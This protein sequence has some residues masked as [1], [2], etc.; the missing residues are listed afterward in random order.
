[1]LWLWSWL[2][3]K[4]MRA[5]YTG[6]RGATMAMS[7]C[8]AGSR[9]WTRVVERCACLEIPISAERR[10]CFVKQQQEGDLACDPNKAFEIFTLLL[11]IT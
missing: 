5:V 10:K 6:Y 7:M 2:P 11:D 3:L 4:L 1:M 9:A 8:M